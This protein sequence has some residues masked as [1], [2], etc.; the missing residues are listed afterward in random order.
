MNEIKTEQAIGRIS[1][2]I[3]IGPLGAYCFVF[4]YF[5]SALTYATFRL[6]ES[7]INDL[8]QLH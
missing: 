1:F 6:S 3:Y 4:I 5:L 7:T 2:S 8:Q